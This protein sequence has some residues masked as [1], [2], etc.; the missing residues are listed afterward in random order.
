MGGT[1]LELAP[2]F[3]QWAVGA[4]HPSATSPGGCRLDGFELTDPNPAR[5]QGLFD[6]VGYAPALRAGERGMRVTLQCPRGRVAFVL[7]GEPPWRPPD[8]T[9]RRVT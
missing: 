1:D 4:P 9:T 7:T 2:Y 6:A 5:L 3:I 8:T